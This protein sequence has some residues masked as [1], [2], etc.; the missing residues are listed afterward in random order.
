MVVGVLRYWH[1]MIK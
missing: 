1:K